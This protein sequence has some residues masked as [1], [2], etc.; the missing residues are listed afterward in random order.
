MKIYTVYIQFAYDDYYDL[1]H[2]EVYLSRQNAVERMNELCINGYDGED[3]DD[4]L[5]KEYDVRDVE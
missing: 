4:V 2:A 5:I 3:I 1:E